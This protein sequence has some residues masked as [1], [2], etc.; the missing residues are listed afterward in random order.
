MSASGANITVTGSGYNT[1]QGVREPVRGGR[2]PGRQQA[3]T[4]FAADPER[5]ALWYSDFAAGKMHRVDLTS[6]TVSGSFDLPGGPGGM[7]GFTET[8]PATG[9]VWV[10]V[11]RSVLVFDAA[12]TLVKTLV[13]KDLARDAA[14]DTASGRAYVV[15]QDGGDLSD[16]ANDNNG[17]LTVYGIE[18]SPWPRRTCRY[19]ATTPRPVRPRSPSNRAAPPSS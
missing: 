15:R 3:G 16:P 17:T 10:G 2:R 12:G 18:D 7:A 5:G 11:D 9:A 19:P 4:Q 6:F 1:A 14:F 8:D 13:G